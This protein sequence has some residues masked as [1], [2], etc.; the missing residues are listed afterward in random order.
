M[1]WS[2]GY[3]PKWERDIGYGVP[4]TCDH[5]GC[6]API[7]R[8]L[9]YVCGQEPYG[10]DYGCGL[11]FCHDHMRSAGAK[12]DHVQLCKKCY[13]GHGK[14]FDPTPDTRE[15]VEHKLTDE[16]WSDWRS[17][18]QC[19]VRS[20]LSSVGATAPREAMFKGGPLDGQLRA[21]P[22]HLDWGLLLAGELHIVRHWSDEWRTEWPYILA[23][24]E[25]GIAQ[26]ELVVSEDA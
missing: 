16:S 7:D 4:A 2:I 17:E 5:P 24:V 14:T 13:H 21:P 26:L 15:W 20:M 6:G 11:Y 25:N 19:I 8:G 10:G 18:N 22:L 1:G 12:R 9:S 23:G 3:D